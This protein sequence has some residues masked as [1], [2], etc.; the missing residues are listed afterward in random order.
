MTSLL[1]AQM[2]PDSSRAMAVTA[3]D[4][5]L[6]IQSTLQP[7]IASRSNKILLV[8]SITSTVRVQRANSSSPSSLPWLGLISIVQPLPGNFEPTPHSLQGKH[9]VDDAAELIGDEF[10]DDTGSV[11]C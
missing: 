1:I 6:G 9:Q 2:K 4:K 5:E 11:A 8:Y 7:T 10:I 3:D